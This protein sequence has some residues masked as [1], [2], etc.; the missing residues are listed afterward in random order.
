MTPER[1][2]ELC[3]ILVSA[4]ELPD[5]EVEGFLDSSCAGDAALRAEVGALA[6]AARASDGWARRMGW[7]DDA[8]RPVP[9]E[10]GSRLNG[11]EI[12]GRLGA[13]GMGEVYRARDA[14]LGRDV[15][16]KVLPRV[17]A[18]DAGSLARLRREAQILASFSHPNIAA[19]H[20]IEEVE[21]SVVLVLELVEGESLAER[22]RRG[23]LAVPEVLAIARETAVGLEAAHARGIV[24]RDLKPDNIQLTRSGSVKLLDFGLAR[25]YAPDG[26]A[27]E[28]APTAVAADV[29]GAWVIAGTPAYMSPEQ[30]RGEAV[31]SRADV[32]AFGATLWEMLTGRPLFEGATATDRLLSV[33]HQ[34]ID[35]GRLPAGTPAP[36]RRLLVRSLERNVSNRLHSIAD[37]RL[38]IEEALGGGGAAAEKKAAGQARPRRLAAMLLAA[39]LLA[40]LPWARIRPLGPAAG[41]PARR[42]MMLGVGF[43]PGYQGAI[44]PDGQTIAFTKGL[45]PYSQQPVALRRVNELQA[46][47]LAGTHGSLNPFFSPDGKWVAYFRTGHLWRIALVGGNPEVVCAA[48]PNGSGV[49][50]EDGTILMSRAVI[51]GR[52]WTGLARVPAAGGVPQALTTVERAQ[53]ERA[54]LMPELLPDGR[55]LLF[56]VVTGR[57]LHIDALSIDGGGRRRVMANASHPVYRDGYLFYHRREKRTVEAVAFDPAR[58]QVWGVPTTVASNVMHD[59]EGR[60]TY[61]LSREGTLVYSDRSIEASYSAARVVWIDRAGRTTPLLAE[62]AA[63]EQPRLS[64]DGA[65]L[66]VRKVASPNCDLW[67]YDFQR[68]TLTRLTTDWDSHDPTWSP[69]GREATYSCNRRGPAYGIES[70]SVD[71]GGGRTFTS[72]AEDRTSPS[73]AGNGRHL[74]FSLASATGGSDVWT[75]EIGKEPIP[76]AAT[77]FDEERPAFSPDGRWIAYESDESGRR[78]I[79]VRPYPGP[80]GKVQVSS[81]G[82]AGA[83]WSRDGREIFFQREGWLMAAR[84][85][86]RSPFR[87]LAARALFEGDFGSS[88]PRNRNYDEGPDGRFVL[89]QRPPTPRQELHVV[90]NWLDLLGSPRTA[91]ASGAF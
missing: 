49:W 79:Y 62:P 21:G 25:A 68:G 20:G 86:G 22:L 51:D 31:D 67:M 88:L 76:F 26:T 16:L 8:P 18:G 4:L 36:V 57:D 55:T 40:A 15:A 11:Y 82:G 60:A 90:L 91:D 54:H 66:L 13:G 19:I 83:L 81:S 69:D 53:D 9:L 6:A 45:P 2:R 74:A 48:D 29:T 84:I 10:A 27:E 72:G 12:V 63:W 32:W 70:L 7:G 1:W 47:E 71:E 3:T 61:A 75:H 44:S 24:Y 78:E 23:P 37:A 28:A 41:E 35:W 33:L 59:E 30:A 14:R 5:G 34:V 58:L 77:P 65:R 17:L 85:V 43:L 87:V 39:G 56:T 73:W 52:R 80:G 89:V 46:R 50:A 42:L 64:P 38:D